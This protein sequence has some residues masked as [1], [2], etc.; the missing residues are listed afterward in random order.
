MGIWLHFRWRLR[1]WRNRRRHLDLIALE[2]EGADALEIANRMLIRDREA[3]RARGGDPRD[4][5]YPKL[6]DYSL[7]RVMS[8]FLLLRAR[9]ENERMLN[10]LR[11]PKRK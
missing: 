3:F 10:E 5:E 9:R 6:G 8:P 11:R 4:P 2:K 7:L 1:I